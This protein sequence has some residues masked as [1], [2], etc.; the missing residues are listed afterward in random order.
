MY[1]NLRVMCIIQEGLARDLIAPCLHHFILVT[2]AT[3]ALHYFL[4]QF[5]PGG[6]VSYLASVVA[7]VLIGLGFVYETFA[8]RFVADAGSAGKRLKREMITRY[9]STRYKR[10]VLGTLLPNCINLEF[11]SS[12]DTIHNGIGMDY[13]IRYV[14]RVVN[15]TLGLLLTVD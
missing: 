6:Q 3:A 11:I 7:V 15:Q 12:V 10:K 2:E 13:F 9:G 4:R 14:E 5:M 1:K 8:I